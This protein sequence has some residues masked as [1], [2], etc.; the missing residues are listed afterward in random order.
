MA[1]DDASVVFEY[2]NFYHAMNDY[3]K[4]QELYEKAYSLEPNIMDIALFRALNYFRMNDTDIET[5]S[6][7]VSL[8]I[9]TNGNN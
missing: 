4:A 2:A 9:D 5:I 7:F 8:A 3:Q 1:P 6:S